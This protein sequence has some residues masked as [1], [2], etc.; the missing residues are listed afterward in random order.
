MCLAQG[1][2]RSEARTGLES[3]TLPLSLCA[4]M[5]WFVVPV[6]SYGHVETM[7]VKS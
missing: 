5:V 1:P 7:L 4:P 3:S 2:Q 6:N